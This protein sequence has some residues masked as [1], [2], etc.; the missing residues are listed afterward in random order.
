MAGI[1]RS[2]KIML[3]NL[4]MY[5]AIVLYGLGTGFVMFKLL[6]NI[7][8]AIF[9]N[10]KSAYDNNWTEWQI[11]SIVKNIVVF[12]FLTVGMTGLGIYLTV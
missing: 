8:K 5:S 6:V 11:S 4:I 9:V 10:Q 12:S 3:E 1:Q 2:I 7:A